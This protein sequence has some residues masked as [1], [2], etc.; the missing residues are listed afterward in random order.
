MQDYGA[1]QPAG[2]CAAIAV[3]EVRAETA[4]FVN[5]SY[6]NVLEMDDIHRT[7]ILHPGPV[8]IPAALACAQAEGVAA[9]EFLEAMVR[10]YD[11]VM[12][13]WR[14]AVSAYVAE[15]AA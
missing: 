9:H 4:A 15:G 8:V 12:A 7:S 13:A 5:G 11:A 3:G 2:P 1:R 14:I 10:G 6:G